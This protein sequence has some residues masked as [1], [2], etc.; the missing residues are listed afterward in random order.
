MVR[1]LVLFALLSIF[2]SVFALSVN[3]GVYG[4]NNIE[5]NLCPLL[6]Y[7]SSVPD[8]QNADFVRQASSE[9]NPDYLTTYQSSQATVYISAQDYTTYYR[10]AWLI[11]VRVCYNTEVKTRRLQLQLNAPSN[12]TLLWGDPGSPN[13][14]HQCVP[15]TPRLMTISGPQGKVWLAGSGYDTKCNVEMIRGDTLSFYD[16]RFH[17][18]PF[19]SRWGQ[20]WDW[21][22]HS[23]G[24]ENLYYF[25]LLDK[26][27]PAFSLQNYPQGKV[28][29]MGI[30]NDADAE[31][32]NTVK[33]IFWG[34]TSNTSHAYLFRGLMA[35]H[36]RISDT[37]WGA[38]WSDVHNL[39]DGL[40]AA[41]NTIGHHTYYYQADNMDSLDYWM[42]RLHQRYNSRLW[43][44]H[45]IGV[46][47]EDIA[48]NGWD[49]DSPSYVMGMLHNYG[50]D[51]AWIEYNRVN[52]FNAFEAYRQLPHRVYAI[53]QSEN[54]HYFERKHMNC[55]EET[56]HPEIS[57]KYIM[58]AENLDDLLRKKGLVIV[59]TH[60]YM[61]TT[62]TRT[63]YW[64]LRNDGEHRVTAAADSVLAMIDYYQQNQGLWVAPVEEIFDRLL[65]TDSLKV[66]HMRQ[67]GHDCIVT[68]RNTGTRPINGLMASING[69]QV[70]IGDLQPG[71]G[72]EIII[73]NTYTDYVAA[74]DGT[75]PAP[76]V[77]LYRQG[78]FLVADGYGYTRNMRSQAILYNVRGQRVNARVTGDAKQTRFD[79]Q[80][81]PSG[82]YLINL[83]GEIK[84]AAF[85]K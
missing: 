30:T 51:Y 65:V 44:D 15:F 57:F 47:P 46:N 10:G 4:L 17:T 82:V 24:E 45:N 69:S 19:L 8:Y 32:Y 52:T 41:G 76:V 9:P 49:P 42:N 78:K 37:V 2:S 80:G 63:G 54:I 7:Y 20:E 31:N 43:I 28:A 35:H 84:K 61:G 23:A 71:Q 39:W 18:A 14:D 77:K 33:C 64:E 11:K 38:D 36:L 85:V 48:Y 72:T 34:S 12:S 58:T 79:M 74:H 26:N 6:Q 5:L 3:D 81:Q 66:T 56:G 55:W 25:L 70:L 1:C 53:P 75:L 59:Y 50:I 60:F 21:Q 13:Q 29:A 40:Y 68:L 67:H 16:N 27:L 22:P 73:P 83:A 62:S